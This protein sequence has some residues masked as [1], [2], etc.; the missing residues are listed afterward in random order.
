MAVMAGVNL[1]FSPELF[2]FMSSVSFDPKI[3]MLL[4]KVPVID[5]V[6][7]APDAIS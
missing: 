1:V 7:E 4:M 5:V 6:L 2:S 3:H